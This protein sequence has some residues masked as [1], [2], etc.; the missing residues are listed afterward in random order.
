MSEDFESVVSGH[1]RLDVDA[2]A[3]THLSSLVLIGT[4][5]HKQW[6]ADVPR[7]TLEQGA[8]G[9]PKWS[10][11]EDL[12]I[13]ASYANVETFACKEEFWKL[14]FDGFEAMM[15]GTTKRY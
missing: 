13:L 14:V 11:E 3:N 1:S 8:E 12:A 9:D 6:L 7:S 5:H 15:E 4:S 2:S 10:P